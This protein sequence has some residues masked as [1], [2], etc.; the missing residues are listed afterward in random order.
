MQRNRRLAGQWVEL[1]RRSTTDPNPKISRS[2]RISF[3]LF[4]MA[5]LIF[6]LVAISALV[7]QRWPSLL[8][9]VFMITVDGTMAAFTY[10]VLQKRR[11]MIP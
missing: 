5:T 8:L 9:A 11:R 7:D 4:A 2:V 10:V 1:W 3:W 6:T